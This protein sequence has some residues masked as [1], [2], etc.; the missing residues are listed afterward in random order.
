M[1][2]IISMVEKCAITIIECSM[3]LKENIVWR[4][5]RAREDSNSL[6]LTRIDVAGYT[7]LEL[8]RFAYSTVKSPANC[9]HS[10]YRDGGSG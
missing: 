3:L 4:L 9:V 7:I 1:R 6:D 10:L 2:E 8:S 5:V